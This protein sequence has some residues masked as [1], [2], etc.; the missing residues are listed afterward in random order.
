M[1]TKSTKYRLYSKVDKISVEFEQE[2]TFNVGQFVINPTT[3]SVQRQ[4][5]QV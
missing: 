1:F 4:K 3:V 5:Q 2:D